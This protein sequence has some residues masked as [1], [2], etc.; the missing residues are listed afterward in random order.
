[1]NSVL[2]GIL[3]ESYSNDQYK[4]F[5]NSEGMPYN[6]YSKQHRK[7]RDD[8]TVHD[9]TSNNVQHNGMTGTFGGVQVRRNHRV[10]AADDESPAIFPN[11]QSS[12]IDGLCI[13]S[14]QSA[15]DMG[16]QGVN[17]NTNGASCYADQ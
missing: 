15:K 2:L 5:V 10:N 4:Y 11:M 16:E 6:G 9:K 3:F 7:E 8:K 13:G 12:E 17:R 1:M 14:K